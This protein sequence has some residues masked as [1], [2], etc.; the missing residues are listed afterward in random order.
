MILNW[1]ASSV[2]FCTTGAATAATC[3]AFARFANP[4]G[5]KGAR[6]SASAVKVE[7]FFTW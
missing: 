5:Q 1:L 3:V 4:I 7:R 2:T 6:A